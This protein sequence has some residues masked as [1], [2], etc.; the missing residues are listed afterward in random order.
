[1]R[2]QC[3]DCGAALY[4]RFYLERGGDSV[5]FAETYVCGAVWLWGEVAPEVRAARR[6]AVVETKHAAEPAP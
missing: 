4:E 6:C 5:L 1:M 3:P 2:T